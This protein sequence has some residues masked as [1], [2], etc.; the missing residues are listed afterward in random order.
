MWGWLKAIV[1]GIFAALFDWGQAQ[2]E[3]PPVIENEKTPE[4][5]KRGWNRFVGDKLRDQANRRD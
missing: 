1:H 5:I 3:K 4:P 2:V